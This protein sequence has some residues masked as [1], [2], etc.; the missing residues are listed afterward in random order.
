MSKEAV[1]GLTVE[2]RTCEESDV[3]TC[4]DSEFL[5]TTSN[6]CVECSSVTS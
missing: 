4:T 3:I 6:K 5:N 1:E 2:L